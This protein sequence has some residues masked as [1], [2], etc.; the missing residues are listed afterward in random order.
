MSDT[1]SYRRDK[2]F[3]P[4][5]KFEK[6]EK[7]RRLNQFLIIFQQVI[8]DSRV[9]IFTA[10]L[11]T[12][13]FLSNSIKPIYLNEQTQT[14]ST[15]MSINWVFRNENLPLLRVPMLKL[16]SKQKL[17]DVISPPEPS[18][19]LIK[20]KTQ[21][22]NVFFSER[23]NELIGDQQVRVVNNLLVNQDNQIIAVEVNYA[24]ELINSSDL[25]ISVSLLDDNRF[26]IQR[27]QQQEYQEQQE[28]S[29][30]QPE[31]TTFAPVG[32]SG[33]SN[34]SPE[35]DD[36]YY[37]YPS[38]LTFLAPLLWAV[39]I[40]FYVI[41]KIAIQQERYSKKDFF[42]SDKP[43]NSAHQD[44]LGFSELAQS[45]SKFLR[46]AFTTA[47]L[48]LSVN[49]PWGKGKSSLMKMVFADLQKVG[50]RPVWLNA[51]HHQNEEQF[52]Y[53]VMSVMRGSVIP[54]TLTVQGIFFR[55][56]LMQI[57]FGRLSYWNRFF[58]AF[59][60]F[61]SFPVTYKLWPFGEEGIDKIINGDF[62]FDTVSFALLLQAISPFVSAAIPV[63]SVYGLSK[64]KLSRFLKQAQGNL[65]ALAK[66]DLNLDSNTGIRHKFA[67][68]FNDICCALGENKLILFIDDLD[69][70][71][72]DRIMEVL[73][74]V[75]FL[76]S[77]GDCYVIIGM[78]EEPVV[79]AIGNHFHK[80]F[81][82]DVFANVEEFR[83]NLVGFSKDYLEKIINISI[84]VP[85]STP[86]EI[87]ELAGSQSPDAGEKPTMGV[88]FPIFC[89]LLFV[90][91]LSVS[92]INP[93][94]LD[95]VNFD[96]SSEEITKNSPRPD[97][98]ELQS[99]NTQLL[100]IDA[101]D[102]KSSDVN[103]RLFVLSVLFLFFVFIA[104]YVFYCMF[105]PI[106][107]THF[108][109]IRSLISV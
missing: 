100:I 18:S 65:I 60:F 101:L 71:S 41:K 1:S 58:I 13:V 80:R 38:L 64:Q 105:R 56:K 40:Y 37:V 104:I 32:K 22:E 72:E 87:A 21:D 55:L 70:C 75:N 31:R 25:P 86:D 89:A 96:L 28:Q 4:E 59:L 85:S 103:M 45:I 66:L 39:V 51:W 35:L 14:Y 6:I 79:R 15:E 16:P 77:S 82:D 44:R 76:A 61:S 67:S 68:E 63:L 30:A 91:I 46:H 57:R 7:G 81:A 3:A 34:D 74:T 33:A 52:L 84:E 10:F 36:Y 83:D 62:N 27:R 53:G 8:R 94:F 78:A 99:Y 108:G 29:Q 47:P 90:F 50:A 19:S 97:R 23:L 93:S 95:N 49:G 11:L 12:V 26:S 106:P 109:S 88:Y 5:D 69:R 98:K 54:D 17:E 48:T 42:A 9:I 102:S 20:E 43:I 2:G 107:I 24:V 92:V 73:E